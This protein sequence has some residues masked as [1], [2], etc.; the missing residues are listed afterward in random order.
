MIYI[1]IWDFLKK[2][3][4]CHKLH[5]LDINPGTDFQKNPGT[6]AG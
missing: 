2:Q 4:F 1:K 5:L 6:S 3:I